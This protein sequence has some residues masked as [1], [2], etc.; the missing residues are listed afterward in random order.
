MA[1]ERKIRTVRADHTTSAR[2]TNETN[3]RTICLRRD[4]GILRQA[5]ANALMHSLR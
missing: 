5:S 2:N 4:K 1:Q 3:T